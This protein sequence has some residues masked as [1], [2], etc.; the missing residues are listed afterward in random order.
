MGEV[1]GSSH[2][3]YIRTFG[4]SFFPLGCATKQEEELGAGWSWGAG[5]KEDW[6]GGGG[7]GNYFPVKEGRK[8]KESK[9]RRRGEVIG[10]IWVLQYTSNKDTIFDIHIQSTKFVVMT[11]IRSDLAKHIYIT[12]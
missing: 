3:T 9:G 7:V 8:G 2:V 6:G 5:A 1:V 10:L 12:R 4:P 11:C